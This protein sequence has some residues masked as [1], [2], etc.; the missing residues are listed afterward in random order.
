MK[1]ATWESTVKHIVVLS[2]I[3][4]IVSLLLAVINSYTAPVI[5]ANEQATTLAAYVDVMPTVERPCG[6]PEHPLFQPLFQSEGKL[7]AHGIPHAQR[8]E[9]LF[10]LSAAG[11]GARWGFVACPGQKK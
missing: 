2:V 8:A 9:P 4:L 7:H 10:Q 3:S 5:K 6:L 1:K 11:G